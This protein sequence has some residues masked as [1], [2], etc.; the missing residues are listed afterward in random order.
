VLLVWRE[1][2]RCTRG[3]QVSSSASR[4]GTITGPAAVIC[5]RSRVHNRLVPELTAYAGGW[6]CAS[7]ATA[8]RF[9]SCPLLS[10]GHL[11]LQSG[12]HARGATRFVSYPPLATGD[13]YL[14]SGSRVHPD[15]L[16]RALHLQSGSHV[17]GATRFVSYPLL[18]TGDLYLQSGSCVRAY[19]IWGY[20]RSPPFSSF[21]SCTYTVDYIQF[22]SL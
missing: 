7:R 17:H 8:T 15:H 22:I 5:M 20:Q 21:A 18:A 12:S 1:K 2:V 3:R 6:L 19:I 14:Q 4:T 16:L 9:E 10:I 11:Q 13:L